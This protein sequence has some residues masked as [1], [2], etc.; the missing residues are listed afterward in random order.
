METVA[1]YS[2]TWMVRYGTVRY[3]IRIR[4]QH[5]QDDSLISYKQTSFTSQQLTF[6]QNLGM[7][8]TDEDQDSK[9]HHRCT[10]TGCGQSQ[11]SINARLRQPSTV[12]K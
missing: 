3:G 6:H 8:R 5:Y 1:V 9:N 7:L 4:A 10:L 2:V 12:S 11:D